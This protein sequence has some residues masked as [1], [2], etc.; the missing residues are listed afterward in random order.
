MI[1]GLK[2]ITRLLFLGF[3]KTFPKKIGQFLLTHK[4]YHTHTNL[5]FSGDD[6]YYGLSK[7]QNSIFGI[8]GE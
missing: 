3:K 1:L 2:K 4:E 7:P 5:T 8:N 6:I